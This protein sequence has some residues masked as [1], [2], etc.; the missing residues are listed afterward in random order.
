MRERNVRIAP[1]GPA[2]EVPRLVF[3]DDS[4]RSLPDEGV[5]ECAALPDV[6]SGSSSGTGG[7]K[8]SRVLAG[9]LALT[10]LIGGGT[11]LLL[12]AVDHSRTSHRASG[13]TTG[14]RPAGTARPA[15]GPRAPTPTTAR[16]V[17]APPTSTQPVTA[18]NVGSSSASYA[19]TAGQIDLTVT[20]T[21]NC[22][23]QVQDPPGGPAIFTGLLTPAEQRS[24]AA[25]GP[26]GMRIGFP[27]GL[28][29][30]VDG[31]AIPLPA[32][33]NPYDLSFVP[34]A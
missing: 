32:S 28:Q 22:W 3:V 26:V 8:R 16:T 23:I 12:L 19:V 13:T 6:G 29:V 20:A 5:T 21:A 34:T 9:G 33:S 1:S 14:A 31:E 2:P 10:L 27:A 15:P 7:P 24:F 11:A 4:L 18:Q 17:A 25:T 30:T